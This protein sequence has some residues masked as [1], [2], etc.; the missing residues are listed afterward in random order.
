MC[1]FRN[2]HPHRVF[3]SR[4]LTLQLC[5]YGLGRALYPQDYWPI[6]K[7]MTVFSFKLKKLLMLNNIASLIRTN[8]LYRGCIFF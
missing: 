3:I 7:G 2:S 1:V 4:Y 5:D 6:L 8:E